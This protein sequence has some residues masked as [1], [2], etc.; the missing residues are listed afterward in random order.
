MSYWK[1]FA[2]D[3]K[4]QII[5][6]SAA[7]AA[8]GTLAA[9]LVLPRTYVITDGGRVVTCTS[10]ATDP[11]Q[12][13]GEAG[14]SLAASD[15]YTAQR[16][17]IRI[18]RSR[19]VAV[20]YRGTLHTVTAGEET[21]AQ[22][23]ARYGLE[24]GDEDTLSVNPGTPVR[25]GMEIRVD[26]QEHR[27]E[28]YCAA[29]PHGTVLCYDSSLPQGVREV[30]IPGADGELLRTAQVTYRNTQE[31]SRRILSEKL[32]IPA[33]DELV[34]VGT[35][36]PR[37]A[38]GPEDMPQIGDG[39]IQLPTGERLHYRGSA[40]VRATAYTHTDAGCD[41]IT[42]TG[43]T[44]HKGTVAVDPRFIP[45]GTRMFILS[46]DGAYVYG[47]SAA[48]DCGGDIKGDRVDLYFPTYRECIQFGRRKCTVY[49]LG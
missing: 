42:Y 23:L 3:R 34:A 45:Y 9:P 46:D 1:R 48:E 21:V 10:F 40:T 15:S 49:F 16:G 18:N 11:D 33:V 19:T 6:F 29:I 28:V 39:Y 8:L 7:L 17:D 32:T 25:E 5:L 37:T 31:V 35:G 41:F 30:L 43:T 44:V 14:L 20:F 27:Q 12:V 2:I 47:L 22:L 26:S 24:P 13:L 4:R 38:P 36:K